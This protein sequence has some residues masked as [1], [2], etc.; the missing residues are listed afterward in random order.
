M[1]RVTVRAYPGHVR[2][3]SWGASVAD[4]TRNRAERQA[5]RRDRGSY[6]SVHPTL[7]VARRLRVEILIVYGSQYGNTQKLAQAMARALSPSHHV[8]VVHAPVAGTL[9]ADAVDL[10]FV[11]APTQM[12]GLR[13]LAKPFL[14]GLEGRG[15][16]G[17]R[18]A[19]FD[20]RM[21]DFA[22]T[23]ASEAIA[24]HLVGAGCRLVAEPESFLVLGLDGPLA[25]GEVERA[26]AWAVGVA[27]S[28]ATPA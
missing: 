10:L 18:A 25:N 19:A 22:Q 27:Q 4:V 3:V 14:I 13:L 24:R 17:V 9:T 1:A 16:G 12:R 15:F 5:R 21:G 7:E 20:T 6:N 23:V 28:V 11:G 2:A 26:A 8:R